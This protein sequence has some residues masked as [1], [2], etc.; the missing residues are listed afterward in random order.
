MEQL[1]K[2][3]DMH[4]DLLNEREKQAQEVDRNYKAFKKIEPSLLPSRKGQFA[5]LR[6]GEI[7]GFYA[8]ARKALLSVRSY[9]R[10]AFSLIKNLVCL[11]SILDSE[12][13]WHLERDYDWRK[14][15]FV[16]VQVTRPGRMKPGI[17]CKR[18]GI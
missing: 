17:L 14:G 12:L 4:A 5:L 7:V 13:D 3:K 9:S 11:P 6:H 10:M 2:T 16:K 1:L 15:I 18:R 8:S